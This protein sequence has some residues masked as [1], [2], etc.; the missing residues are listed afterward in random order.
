M[1]SC[2]AAGIDE[3]SRCKYNQSHAGLAFKRVHFK[4]S[5]LIQSCQPLKGI[6]V[7]ECWQS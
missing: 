3:G 6:I 4:M 2:V 7:I 1:D 5:R